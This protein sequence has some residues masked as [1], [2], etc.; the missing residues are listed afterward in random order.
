MTQLLFKNVNKVF[1]PRI[2]KPYENHAKVIKIG[3]KYIA[4]DIFYLRT[5]TFVG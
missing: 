5:K 2:I 1:D 3:D 4:A